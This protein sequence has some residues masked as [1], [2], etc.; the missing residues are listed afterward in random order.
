[1]TDFELRPYYFLVFTL[2]GK[3]TFVVSDYC[4]RAGLRARGSAR[5]RGSQA[6]STH[7]LNTQRVSAVQKV[8]SSY[9]HAAMSLQHG[10]TA[11]PLHLLELNVVHVH[12][13]NGLQQQTQECRCDVARQRSPLF[14]GSKAKNRRTLQVGQRETPM[15]KIPFD[16]P[17]SCPLLT[18]SGSTCSHECSAQNMASGSFPH[19]FT[20]HQCNKNNF[21]CN[22]HRWKCCWDQR[23]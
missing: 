12:L 14:K 23:R 16:A 6:V 2:N 8:W 20:R 13:A 3:P 7:G 1:V 18:A 10:P 17:H 15:T 5:S 19:P 4:W 9:V 21:H 11:H 22:S